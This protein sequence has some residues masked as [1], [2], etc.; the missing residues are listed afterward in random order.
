VLL[1]LTT[2]GIFLLSFRL[3][4]RSVQARKLFKQLNVNISGI[5]ELRETCRDFPVVL[6]P[7]HRWGHQYRETKEM[8]YLLIPLSFY[9]DTHRDKML[10]G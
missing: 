2:V 5:E 3:N 1:L 10:E 6:L 7:T 8:P 4:V 9:L